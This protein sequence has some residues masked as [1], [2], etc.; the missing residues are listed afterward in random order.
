MKTKYIFSF[1]FTLILIFCACSSFAQSSSSSSAVKIT[2]DYKRSSTIA[3]NQVA[4]WIQDE[5]G[6]L[7]KTIYASNFTSRG[8]GYK[9]RE[10]SLNHWVSAANPDLLTNKEIDAVSGA[11]LR[12]GKREF[13][14]DLTDSDGNKVVAGKYF[15]NLEGTLYW[16][17]NVLFFTQIDVSED[18]KVQVDEIEQKRS[19]PENHQNEDMISNVKI[20]AQVPAQSQ[21][22]GLSKSSSSAR[23]DNTK[24]WLGGLSPEDALNYI[25][26]NYDKGLVI[27]EV[28]TDYWKLKNGFSGA[29]HI[30][31]DQM[32]ARYDEIPSGVPVI[33]HCGAGVVS[34]PAY[35]TLKEKR[36]DILQL[37]YIA[38]RPPVSEFNKWLSEHKK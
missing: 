1:S 4:L 26:E 12:N 25:E 35:E 22:A 19:E 15:A 24:N 31:H 34:V 17:S 33:L 18:G 36:P 38:G 2:F 13:T 29:M 27:V 37:S 28:N 3:S 23:I 21:D 20:F 8:R 6:K 16:K 9:R 10:D 32:A 5:S 14:W 7:V 30:P 11:T